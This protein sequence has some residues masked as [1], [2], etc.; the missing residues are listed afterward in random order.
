VP[1]QLYIDGRWQPA[2]DGATIPVINPATEEA[3]AHVAAGGPSDVGRAVA[4]AKRA[5]ESWRRT[6]GSE[7]SAF[8]RAIASRVRE[9]RDE[10]M[11]LSSLNNGKPLAEAAVDMDDVAAAFDYYADL[12]RD[13]DE[14][15]DAP[16]AL[17]DAAFG[18][19][20]RFE[21]AGVAALIVPWNFPLVTTAWKVA[22]A[23][24][25][26]C[27]VVLKPSEITPL[28]ELELGNIA[29]DVG[30]PAGVLNIVVG[31]GP[32][33]GAPLVAHPEIAK[34]SFTGSNAVGEQVIVAAARD[35][36]N[37]SLE[38]GGKSPILVFGDADLDHAV[39]CVVAGI[40]YNCGQMCSATSRL[41]V[42]AR[43]AEPLLERLVAAAEALPI[44][45]PFDERVRMGPLT[46]AAHTARST[47]RSS[48]AS[49]PARPCALAVVAR[50]A[51][52]AAI[53]S[54]RPCS[55]MFRSIARC[56][57][58][59]SLGRCSPCGPS[60]TSRKRSSSRTTATMAWS[61]PSSPPI[62]RG[63]IAWRPRSRP[64]TSGSTARR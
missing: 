46:T 19:S 34:I 27:T 30:L 61:R 10:L 6:T 33:V 62:R 11:R 41:L 47:A 26:G 28:V 16:V 39:D 53:S 63:P 45:D 51:W 57:A 7:R 4:A 43:I 13:L 42:E 31:T 44:G 64:A 21:P 20:V 3:I 48:A 37:V 24:A 2:T 9:R 52:S 23:L 56:G 1:E 38:L 60:R 29:D 40:F 36:K 35:T 15:Q 5:F 49:R 8:L 18:A 12:A 50:L 59:R 32:A 14:R 25:A 58:R 55:R 54:V 22:P 17:P